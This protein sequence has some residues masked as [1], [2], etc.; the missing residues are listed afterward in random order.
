MWKKRR[1]RGWTER[2]LCRWVGGGACGAAQSVRSVISSR[3]D[4]GR[5]GVGESKQARLWKK[6]KRKEIIPWWK[7][8]FVGWRRSRKKDGHAPVSN[9]WLGETVTISKVVGLSVRQCHQQSGPRCD[10]TRSGWS[11]WTPATIPAALLLL[12]RHWGISGTVYRPAA[13]R[14][15]ISCTTIRPAHRPLSTGRHSTHSTVRNRLRLLTAVAT[16]CWIT[17]LDRAHPSRFHI[18]VSTIPYSSVSSSSGR[19]DSGQCSASRRG[20]SSFRDWFVRRRYVWRGGAPR[21]YHRV[22]PQLK[23]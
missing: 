18:W 17:P 10:R 14:S 7:I 15:R 22:S 19:R 1:G 20:D 12:R 6:E 21:R 9:W 11:P 13:I 2:R 16:D 3:G 4:G 23:W 5:R 8:Y